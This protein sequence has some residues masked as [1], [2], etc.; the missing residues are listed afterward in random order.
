M[1]LSH[2]V[3]K[4]GNM[5]VAMTTADIQTELKVEHIIETIQ[6]T[7]PERDAYHEEKLQMARFLKEAEEEK[8]AIVEAAKQDAFEARKEA[9]AAGF[10]AGEIQG[11]EMGFQ[12]GYQAGLEAAQV[13]AEKLKQ[14]AHEMLNTAS[15]EVNAF[16]TAKREE[17]IALA[18]QMA[19]KVIHE[20][21]NTSDEK[22]I[23]LLEPILSRMVQES[24]FI[25]LT[26]TP[27]LQ[28]FTKEKLKDLEKTF[29]LYRFAVLVD[30][31]LEENGCIIETSHAIV[32]LQVKQQLDAMVEELSEMM[33]S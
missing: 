8:R 7:N 13:E 1:Q 26:V 24:K 31:S 22:I 33:V 29:P 5:A 19:E 9:E 6:N 18:A 16:Y 17:I 2:R 12:S 4:A 15:Q 30:S 10:R 27:E 3:I 25:T 21:I 28:N 20:K 32:D 11:Q 14:T 23:A